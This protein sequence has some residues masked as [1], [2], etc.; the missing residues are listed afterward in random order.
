[1]SE[2][3]YPSL[4]AFYN[5]MAR[6]AIDECTLSLL[7]KL[8]TPDVLDD[9]QF[10]PII[11]VAGAKQPEL[12]NH[13]RKYTLSLDLPASL[14]LYPTVSEDKCSASF[15][16][17]DSLAGGVSYGIDPRTRERA[18][19]LYRKFVRPILETNQRVRPTGRGQLRDR[20]FPLS[21]LTLRLL[22]LQLHPMK[23]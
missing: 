21:F 20:I 14:T 19:R 16:L 22:F 15:R 9:P 5:D 12:F 1:M 3:K 8:K 23:F 13:Y 2:P 18:K 10:L 6:Q 7:A 17:I 4:V 11:T